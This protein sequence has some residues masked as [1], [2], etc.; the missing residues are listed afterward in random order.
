MPLPRS[1]VMVD[2][3]A[4]A[5]M[6]RKQPWLHSID[7]H[8]LGATV[9]ALLHTQKDGPMPIES[10]G[11]RWRVKL[12]LPTGPAARLWNR[13][14]DTLLNAPPPGEQH[15]LHA[16]ANA[17]QGFLDESQDRRA[18]LKHALVESAAVLASA[19]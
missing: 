4:C 3:Y 17:L 18:R 1:D 11:G 2:G 8:A 7:Y 14:F 12:P 15:D 19:E 5:E 13:L 16:L 6:R 10:D 9:H